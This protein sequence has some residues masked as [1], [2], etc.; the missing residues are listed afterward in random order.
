MFF[1]TKV[2]LKFVRSRFEA[3]ARELS[4]TKN[5]GVTFQLSCTESDYE[6]FAHLVSS[7]SNEN[8]PGVKFPYLSNEAMEEIKKAITDKSIFSSVSTAVSK[9]TDREPKPFL[10][11]SFSI[12][13]ILKIKSR[14]H[15][16]QNSPDF[17]NPHTIDKIFNDLVAKRIR[18][19]KNVKILL[20]TNPASL[21]MSFYTL[22]KVAVSD[23][24]AYP[25][26]P[27]IDLA[28]FSAI[29][30]RY[31]ENKISELTGFE[32]V[33]VKVLD[34]ELIWELSTPIFFHADEPVV[35]YD[36][37]IHDMKPINENIP[38][39]KIFENEIAPVT[40]DEISNRYLREHETLRI[41]RRLERVINYINNC[42]KNHENC[43]Y[44]YESHSV[45]VFVP[46]EEFPE[47][48]VYSVAEFIKNLYIHEGNFSC[49]KFEDVDP[50]KGTV[51]T[52]ELSQ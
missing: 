24:S 32:N 42:L 46:F 1:T 27:L 13:D 50:P 29:Q 9:I 14:R 44:D 4:L 17:V 49:V 25:F 34:N 3:K 6:H 19:H 47:I 39:T 51:F 52:F 45:S 22:T 28:S 8:I 10:R 12:D 16:E 33:N 7:L 15:N 35:N 48:D 40:F 20:S 2:A 31:I 26:P 43:Y 41:K 23:N 11:M 37:L 18:N 36:K 38:T 5:G 30:W 21:S